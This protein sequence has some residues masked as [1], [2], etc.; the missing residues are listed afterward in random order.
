M[1]VVHIGE[2]VNYEIFIFATEKMFAELEIEF[3]M[4]DISVYAGMYTFYIHSAWQYE[5]Q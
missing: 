5:I 1:K 2:F 3:Y 4:K